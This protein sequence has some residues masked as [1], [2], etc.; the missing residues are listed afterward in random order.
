MNISEFAK[1]AG[2]SKST[3]SLAF[4]GNDKI[5]ETTRNRILELAKR[6]DYRP[7]AVARSMRHKYTKSICLMLPDIINPFFPGILKGVEEVAVQKSYT[8]VF[9]NFDGREEN[10]Q[11]HVEMVRDRWIDG[12]IYCGLTGS[13][14]EEKFIREFM[15][16]NIPVVFVDRG[17]EGHQTDTVMIDNYDAGYRAT[18]YLTGL[19]HTRIGLVN[20]PRGVFILNRRTQGY[21]DAQSEAGIADGESMIVEGHIAESTAEQAVSRFLSLPQKPSAI[22]VPAGDILAISIQTKLQKRGFRIPEDF[23]ILGFDDLPIASIV[24]PA[25][26]TVAQPFVEM[27]REAMRMLIRNIESEDLHNRKIVFDAK[28]VIRESTRELS[29]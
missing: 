8:V 13:S 11:I 20:G 17:L 2:V 7:S 27:G 12:V 1:I 15:D 29:K 14:I 9:S 23:S 4:N 3:V 28:L 25:L 16:S 5:P 10:V 22:F 19:G 21:L 6:Y 26:S 18:K 24:S